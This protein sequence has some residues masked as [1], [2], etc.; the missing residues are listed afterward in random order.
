MIIYL[1]V[2]LGSETPG[3]APR[4]VLA[5]QKPWAPKGKNSKITAPRGE[6]IFKI[7]PGGAR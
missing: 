1:Y 5:L 3:G 6:I 2:I 7:A 4:G